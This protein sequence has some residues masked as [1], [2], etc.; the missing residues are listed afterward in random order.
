MNSLTGLEVQ[1]SGSANEGMQSVGQY[2]LT[3]IV[4]TWVRCPLSP[5]LFVSE[6]DTGD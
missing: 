1:T 5:L 6:D 4:H 2:L 3:G